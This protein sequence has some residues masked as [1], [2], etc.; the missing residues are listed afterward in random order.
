MANNLPL[1]ERYR[2]LR[3]RC[4]KIEGYIFSVRG[5]KGSAVRADLLTT[6]N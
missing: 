1:T 5:A 3:D 2:Q 4:G 6:A